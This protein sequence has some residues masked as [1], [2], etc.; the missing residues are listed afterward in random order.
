MNKIVVLIYL[1]FTVSVGQN[2]VPNHSFEVYNICPN[3]TYTN[4][5]HF[6]KNFNDWSIPF[7]HNGTSDY[8]NACTTSYPNNFIGTQH[9]QH[10]I[11]YIGLCAYISG[12]PNEIREYVMTP[13][14]STLEKGVSYTLS[15]W[16]SLAD[17]SGGAINGLGMAL[18]SDGQLKKFS[19]N[20][21]S[22]FV[23]GITPTLIANNVIS[24]KVNW[25]QLTTT[26]IA[27]GNEKHLLIGNMLSG[28]Q[29]IEIPLVTSNVFRVSYY[30]IDNISVTKTIDLATFNN[31]KQSFNVYPNPTNDKIYID[32]KEDDITSLE[33]FDAEGR[34]I[35]LKNNITT[36]INISSIASGIYFL[37]I[38]SNIGEEIH[39]I[40]KK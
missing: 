11:G 19:K 2:L 18:L 38:K 9:A 3:T 32:T 37:K 39:K 23:Y 10:G 17:N 40:I 6:D 36:E 33:L 22:G 25:Q 34:M 28:S 24:D 4:Y 35:P 26:Y 13:L 16:V 20:R 30:Y 27:K 8:Y 12:Y 31:R 14:K 5:Q 21:I 1:F 29:T 7:F 15:M